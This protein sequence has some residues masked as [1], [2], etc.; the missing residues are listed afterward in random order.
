MD[1]EVPALIKVVIGDANP[2]YLELISCEL[3][4]E[5]EIAVIGTASNPN[6][7][8]KLV[9]QYQPDIVVMDFMDII[10]QGTA[11]VRQIMKKQPLT[12]V[13]VISEIEDDQFVEQLLK[14]GVA[15]YMIKP[16]RM[17]DLIERIKYIHHNYGNMFNL[18]YIRERRLIQQFL[19]SCF[20]EL[21]IPPNYKGHR[22][23]IDAILLVSQDDSWLNGIT[24]RLYPAVARGNHTTASHVER[25]IR[26]A[27][28]TAWAKGDLEHLQKFFP[29]AIDPA[30]G[31][32]TN[33][34]FI[35]KMADLIK[36][37]FSG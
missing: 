9:S 13:L 15:Y 36:I 6:D 18:F 22:Y 29:Y 27:I 11:V 14:L 30:K 37:R 16:F 19:V 3:K 33:A 31:K 17:P 10:D 8:S 2:K 20:A 25:S 5:L 24:K 1:V 4:H 7:L 28:D 26:Y 21:G 32:P 34:A 12:Q 23:L 35:A